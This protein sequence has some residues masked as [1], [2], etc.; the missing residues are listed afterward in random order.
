MELN[1]LK[2]GR[3]TRDKSSKFRAE[4]KN[5]INVEASWKIKVGDNIQ[6]TCRNGHVNFDLNTTVSCFDFLG[7]TLVTITKLL[8]YRNHKRQR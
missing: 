3:P 7:L 2:N 5:P 8:Y 6:V 1:V 4:G